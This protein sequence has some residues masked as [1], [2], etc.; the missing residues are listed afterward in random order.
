[1]N[2][3]VYPMPLGR[4]T[5][6]AHEKGIVSIHFGDTELDTPRK[7]SALTN[8][9]ATQIQEYFAGKRREFDLPLD[10]KGTDFQLTVWKALQTV[11]YGETRTY[12]QIAE[13]IGK[14]HAYRAVGMA[15]NKNPIPILIPCHRVIGA[16]NALVG[17]A[18]GVKIKRYLL[19]LEGVDTSKMR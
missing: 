8:K 14:P 11:P 13:A 18:A 2:H 1:M 4:L 5:I 15:N 19:G 7:P 12:A 16:N 9:A 17:Y 6:A 10:P 3:F